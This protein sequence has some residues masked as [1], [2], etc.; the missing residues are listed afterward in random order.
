MINIL[1]KIT[2]KTKGNDTAETNNQDRAV[3]LPE[4]KKKLRHKTTV[5]S[6]GIDWRLRTISGGGGK[7]IGGQIR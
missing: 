2:R 6:D 5:R 1:Q 7:A 3:Q 4:T